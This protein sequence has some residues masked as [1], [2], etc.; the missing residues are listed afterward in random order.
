MFD[1]TKDI[2]PENFRD[3]LFVTMMQCPNNSN[4]YAVLHGRLLLVDIL[5][6][7]LETQLQFRGNNHR[8]TQVAEG[9]PLHRMPCSHLRAQVDEIIH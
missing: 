6:S 7:Y 9:A 4:H 5:I 2:V 8:H 3:K 1:R